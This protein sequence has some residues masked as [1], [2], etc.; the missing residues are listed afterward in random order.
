VPIKTQGGRLFAS[1]HIIIS[2]TFFAALVGR[3]G[4]I[5][6]VREADKQRRFMLEK[7]LDEDWIASICAEMDTDGHG[8]DKLEF[9]VGMLTKLGVEMC[10]QPLQWDDIKPMLAQFDAADKTK[11][12]R[13]N[14]EDLRK[15]VQMKKAKA[16]EAKQKRAPQVVPQAGTSACAVDS[17]PP[18]VIVAAPPAIPSSAD[19]P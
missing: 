16:E 15:L 6:S 13:L 11:D 4:E 3:I 9:V 10:G 12:G 18:A 1:F 7:E 19:A 8:V 5:R 17:Q 14:Q 2:V